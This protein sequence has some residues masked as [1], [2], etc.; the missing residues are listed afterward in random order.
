MES[1]VE[2]LSLAQRYRAMETTW[3]WMECRRGLDGCRLYLSILLST[4]VHDMN[5]IYPQGRGVWEIWAMEAGRGSR[6]DMKVGQKM[7]FRE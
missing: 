7:K 6:D 4:M 5:I 2:T 3:E 1:H